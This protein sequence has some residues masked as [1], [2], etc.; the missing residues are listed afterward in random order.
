MNAWQHAA[1][2]AAYTA[3]AVVAAIAL[4]GFAG[5][6]A[7]P[8]VAGIAVFAVGAV[9]HQGWAL[10]GERAQV[11]REFQRLRKAQA[12]ASEDLRRTQAEVAALQAAIGGSGEDA[13][14]DLVGEMRVIRGLLKKVTDRTAAAREKR[15]PGIARASAAE[16]VGGKLTAEQIL[17]ITRDGLESNRVD[18]YLQ[19]VVSLP[20]R[21]V[22]YYEAFS[23]IRNEAG[24]VILPEQYLSIAADTG[25]IGTI[26]NLLL[27]RCVQLVR[28]V[29]RDKLD[30]GFFCNLSRYALSDR[31]FFPQFVEFLE[32]N[33]DLSETLVFELRQ[34][35]VDDA[36]LAFNLARL[37]K[38]GFQFSMDKVASLDLD[39]DDLSRRFFRFVKIEA[40][41]LL[42]ADAQKHLAVHVADLKEAMKRAG[43]DLIAEK[44]EEEDEVLGLL[45]FNVDFGQGFLFGEPRP[46]QEAS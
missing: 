6:A 37:R 22:C 12:A 4:S 26:D 21:K 15:E 17:E 20:Q 42:S 45:E 36:E 18:L 46:L 14:Q 19:P 29:R 16:P 25:L 5:G 41:K 28:R 9:L 39:F 31:E 13:A 33:P 23:R 2:V 27:F 44:I 10:R 38:L 34:A 3:V 35:D 43:I 32:R 30:V 8:V 7:L 11:R 24:N 40:S 1:A